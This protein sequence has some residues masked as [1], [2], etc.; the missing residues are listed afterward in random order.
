MKNRYYSLIK[1]EAKKSKLLEVD[2]E[3]E[4]LISSNLLAAKKLEQRRGNLNLNENPR[5]SR[6]AKIPSILPE[7][8]R[9]L[10][11]ELFPLDFTSQ[12]TPMEYPSRISLSANPELNTFDTLKFLASPSNRS[13]KTNLRSGAL[14]DFM[15]SNRSFNL[16]PCEGMSPRKDINAQRSSLE[17]KRVVNFSTAM[18]IEE[19]AE[20]DVEEEEVESEE[21]FRRSSFRR[22]TFQDFPNFPSNH[23]QR[24]KSMILP[25]SMESMKDETEE[26]NVDFG[27]KIGFSIKRSTEISPEN[28][29]QLEWAL[30]DKKR[31]EL[32]LQENNDLQTYLYTSYAQAY[33]QQQFFPYSMPFNMAAS[34]QNL[35]HGQE[36]EEEKN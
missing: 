13:P 7:K 26:Q 35:S 10:M 3:A 5:K 11:D 25:S 20:S 19:E 14:T 16:I 8:K 2:E 9:S 6:K 1:N 32:F 33:Q 15:A 12:K 34:N 21:K 17:D 22:S 4:T 30:V 29:N 24:H 28:W 18:G 23:I 31:K 27:N 36:M